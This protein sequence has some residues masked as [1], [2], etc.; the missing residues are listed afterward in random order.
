MTIRASVLDDRLLTWDQLQIAG[1]KDDFAD[2]E[3]AYQQGY[4]FVRWLD[5]QFGDGTFVRTVHEASRRYRPRWDGV[6]ESVIGTPAREL[7]A[8]HLTD[9]RARYEAQER[10][11]EAAGRVEGVELLAESRDVGAPHRIH[12]GAQSLLDP[13]QLIDALA[14][15]LAL[16]DLARC[17]EQ[18][19]EPLGLFGP[20][21]LDLRR[22]RRVAHAA[23]AV[24]TTRTLPPS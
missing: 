16:P 3:R 17:V 20:I 2:G 7:Y 10:A 13:R 1:A 9:L 11:I 5:Q 24:R 21:A 6:L 12:R 15:Q 18:K 4:A 22:H 19:P 23:H 8:E 14:V